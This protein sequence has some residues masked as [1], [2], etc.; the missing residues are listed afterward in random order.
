LN[1]KDI[2]IGGYYFAIIFLVSC[3]LY[4]VF[5]DTI[6]GFTFGFFLAIFYFVNRAR[7]VRQLMEDFE[8]ENIN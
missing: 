7:E 6:T 3:V 4:D 2:F 8:D 1:K 5:S